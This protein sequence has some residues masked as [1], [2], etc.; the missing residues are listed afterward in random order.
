MVRVQRKE[1]KGSK[2]YPAGTHTLLFS[3]QWYPNEK[4]KSTPTKTLQVD[5]R[6]ES[7]EHP[8]RLP[9]CSK[10]QNGN[11][12]SGKSGAMALLGK[13]CLSLFTQKSPDSSA[14]DKGHTLYT[15]NLAPNSSSYL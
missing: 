8:H 2:L 10:Y 1:H 6:K 9:A 12:E 14:G 5:M 13:V 3:S 11:W 15:Y 4:L 7:E